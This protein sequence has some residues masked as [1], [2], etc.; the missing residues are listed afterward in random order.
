MAQTGRLGSSSKEKTMFSTMKPK[1]KRVT[2]WAMKKGKFYYGGKG[3]DLPILFV[4][5]PKEEDF[6]KGWKPVKVTVVI[7]G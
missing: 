3:N 5:P 6:P 2:S 4:S 7:H 1:K